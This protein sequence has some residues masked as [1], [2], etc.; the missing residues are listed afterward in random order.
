MKNYIKQASPY[1][2]PTADN[3]VIEEH[4]G[5]ASSG[6]KKFSVAHMIA[7]PFWSELHQNP[8]FDEITILIKGRKIV[9]VDGEKIELNAGESILVRKGARVRYSN[10]FPEPNEYWAICIPAFN[11]ETVNRE[12]PEHDSRLK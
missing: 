11:L 4:I 1:V 2:V 10:P 12:E 6:D 5:L 9:E 7:P 3:K 8:E